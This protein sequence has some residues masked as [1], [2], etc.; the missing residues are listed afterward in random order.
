MICTQATDWRN[1]LSSLALEKLDSQ[2]SVSTADDNSQVIKRLSDRSLAGCDWSAVSTG[3]GDLMSG[4]LAQ[5][6]DQPASRAPPGTV[7]SQTPGREDIT[8]TS[9]RHHWDITEISLASRARNN[10]SPEKTGRKS[11]EWELCLFSEIAR[12]DCEQLD[13][14]WLN[15]YWF[16]TKL[17]PPESVTACNSASVLPLTVAT[18]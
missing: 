5:C 3:G 6:A 15:F 4:S 11:W 9:L 8:E 13:G 14:W 10:H 16:N 7:T 12:P 2:V 18:I 17:K 1:T